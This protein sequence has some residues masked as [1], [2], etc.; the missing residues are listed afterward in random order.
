MYVAA[1]AQTDQGKVPQSPYWLSNMVRNYCSVPLCVSVIVNESNPAPHYSKIRHKKCDEAKPICQ[2]CRD[3]GY[4]CD[5]YEQPQ[6][7]RCYKR[8]TNAR[9]KP[10]P[11]TR[12]TS[13]IILA[14][15]RGLDMLNSFDNFGVL[16]ASPPEKSLFLHANQYTIKDLIGYSTSLSGF[17]RDFVLP[18]GHAVNP[19]KHAL[20]SLGASHKSF[21]LRRSL[22]MPPIETQT[23]DHLAIQQYN[24]A[25]SELTPIMSDP[26]PLDIQAILI[27]C[28]LFV[29]IDNLNGRHVVALQHLRAGA[30]VL[31]SMQD[32]DSTLLVEGSSMSSQVTKMKYDE[33]SLGGISDMFERLS[34]DTSILM[35]DPPVHRQRSHALSGGD[36][37]GPFLSSSAARDELRGIDLEFHS[38]WESDKHEDMRDGPCGQACGK[39]CTD[40]SDQGYL[41]RTRHAL[42]YPPISRKPEFEA[43]CDRF[44]KWCSRFDQYLESINHTPASVEEFNEAMVLTLHRKVWVAMLK[45]GPFCDCPLP[46]KYYEDIL[47]Q[48]EIVI[49]AASRG[50]HPM[51]TFEA[52]TIP[53]VSFVASFCEHE[54]L[55]RRAI[56][57]LRSINRTE[58]AWDSQRMADICELELATGVCTGKPSPSRHMDCQGLCANPCASSCH[59][60]HTFNC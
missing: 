5:G 14:S 27:C 6:E 3:N 1:K 42:I 50:T 54:D 11:Q 13:E 58:G 44:E 40:T 10:R 21:L 35:W 53:P 57:M 43:I 34:L 49:P 39:S 60:K 56:A 41:L 55:R 17:W 37:E 24:K 8:K 25:I 26:S 15:N 22:G 9:P 28:L 33:S 46:R 36:D 52:D 30:E 7:P 19:V 4:K 32:R 38:I 12:P 47:H 16:H 2:R 23:Y 59:E 48:A 29:C 51:F 31:N 20:I 18:I 45:S